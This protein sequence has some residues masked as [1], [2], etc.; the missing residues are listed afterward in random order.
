[1]ADLGREWDEATPVSA[2]E[3][4]DAEPIA[5]RD[6]PLHE[7]ALAHGGNA[8]GLGAGPK[9]RG[10]YAA[11]EGTGAESGNPLVTAMDVLTGLYRKVTGDP[12]A[13]QRYE[14][15]RGAEAAYLDETAAANPKTALAATLVGGAPTAGGI[16]RAAPTVAGAGLLPRVVSGASQ[17]ATVGAA[18]GL[19][20][21]DA[22]D[23]LTGAVGGAVGGGAAPV[24]AEGVSRVTGPV[25]DY[26]A[27]KLRGVAEDAARRSTGATQADISKLTRENPNRPREI[28]AALLDE[29]VRLRS[30]KTLRGDAKALRGDIGQEIGALVKQADAAGPTFDLHGVVARA[31]QDILAPLRADPLQKATAERVAAY[32]DD[33]VTAR[34]PGQPITASEAHGIRRQLDAFLRGVRRAQ[35]PDSSFIKEAL[36]DF[37]GLVDDELGAAM[38]KAGLGDAWSEANRRFSLAADV[39]KLAQKGAD[40]RE[41]NRTFGFAEQVAGAGGLAGGLG[42]GG[43]PGAVLGYVASAGAAAGARR[44]GAPVTARVTDALSKVLRTNPQALGPHARQL[45]VMESQRGPEGLAAAHYVL[46]QTSPDYR[47]RW[48][49]VSAEGEGNE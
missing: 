6:V 22:S 28:G 46:S 36:N 2:S 1:M 39:Q 29:D 19:G 21:G 43:G 30:P 45:L 44:F 3:W 49:A 48:Q 38:N 41:G 27:G 34:P 14:A 42:M 32:L 4:D 15:S 17:G 18:Y 13:A 23:A 9:A 33:L 12:E 37:R 11:G 35:D 8:F 16:A 25:R 47:M 31:Q 20:S 26:V 10:L 7:T 40:R 5:S 24:V